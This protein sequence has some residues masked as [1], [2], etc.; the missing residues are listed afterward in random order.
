MAPIFQW[1]IRTTHK[2][3]NAGYTPYEII[4]GLKPRFVLDSFLGTPTTVR[5]ISQGDYVTKLVEYLKRVH[6]Y[7][8]EQHTKIREGQEQAKARKLG[9]AEP[10]QVGDY[11]LYKRGQLAEGISERA[12]RP[13]RNVVYQIVQAPAP[14]YMY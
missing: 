5:S 4:T 14:P 1:T 9:V 2:K 7:V 12:Q 13:W 8:G 3:F 6:K 11:V 10:L